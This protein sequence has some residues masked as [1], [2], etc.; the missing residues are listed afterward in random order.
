MP[1]NF[2]LTTQPVLTVGN[3]SFSYEA[4]YPYHLDK[5]LPSITAD[6]SYEVLFPK[7]TFGLF[8]INRGD[9]QTSN[10][11]IVRVSGTSR[12]SYFRNYVPAQI[13]M[14]GVRGV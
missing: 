11:A 4:L 13:I 7:D 5:A 1:C 3:P 10:S 6:T 14:R 12:P 9:Y 8:R 2:S